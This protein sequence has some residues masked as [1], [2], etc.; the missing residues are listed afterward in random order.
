[1]R[2]RAEITTILWRVVGPFSWPAMG[3]T[4]EC[5]IPRTALV[6]PVESGVVNGW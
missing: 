6:A 3:Q 1:M 2:W 5:N 4:A